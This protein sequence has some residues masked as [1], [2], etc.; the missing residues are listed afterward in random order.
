VSLTDDTL[1]V[2]DAWRTRGDDV[3][4]ATVVRTRR[5]APRPL[6]S[7]FAVSARGDMAGSVSGGCVEGAVV[8]EAQAVLAGGEPK[9]LFY[10]IADDEAWDVGLACGG[11]VWIWLERY[12]GWERP[13]GR[14]ARVTVVEGDGAGAFLLVTPDGEASGT[15]EPGS[16][17]YQ[18]VEAGREAIARE[19]NA[20]VET[21]GAVLFAEAIVP[22]PRVVIVG[23]VDTAEALCAMTK[24]LGWRTAVI[25]PRGAFATA[26]RM[27][28]A[29]E[30]VVRW[31][32]EGFDA[33]GLRPEDAVVILTH[34]PKLDDPAIRGALARVAGY[35][36]ALGSRR[37]QERRRARLIESGVDPEEL[38]R[39]AGPVGLDIGAF[40]PEETALSILG[41][42][43]AHRAGR[44]GGRLVQANGR[45]HPVDES[46]EGRAAAT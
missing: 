4:L 38:A 44:E 28:S 10:G 14:A 40:T 33:V 5:S 19:R 15:I 2:A 45:I 46:V 20:T 1:R 27:P 23:A 8:E 37:T 26:E 17:R 30:I 13:A 3:A 7:K 32:E 39:V 16:L 21:G 12:A 36:G 34:D 35:I 6:G 22:P 43:V 41:E 31:P 18:A 42:I 24:R 25:D 29:D 11:E 9:L